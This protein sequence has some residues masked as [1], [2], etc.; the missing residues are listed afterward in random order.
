MRIPCALISA[1]AAITF[2][3]S[4]SWLHKFWLH[5]ELS[6]AIVRRMN[7]DCPSP[8]SCR[9]H[10]WE[11]CADAKRRRAGRLFHVHACKRKPEMPFAHAKKLELATQPFAHPALRMR[12]D[13]QHVPAPAN[14]LQRWPAKGNAA[15]STGVLC[16]G[17]DRCEREKDEPS[18]KNESQSCV[19]HNR[20]RGS[21]GQGPYLG[22]TRL[23]CFCR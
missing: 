2:N 8:S 18:P 4:G 7:F 3:S 20:L 23:L 5:R 22:A 15:E 19:Q 17:G 1:S 13:H 12:L 9:G 11:T 6:R 21:L 10:R 14:R 16:A